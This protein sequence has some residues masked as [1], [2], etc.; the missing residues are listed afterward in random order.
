MATADIS[1][2]TLAAPFAGAPAAILEK[3]LQQ[4]AQRRNAQQ[5]WRGIA[6]SLTF[7]FAIASLMVLA[8]RL[9]FVDGEWWMPLIVI[10]LA[11]VVGIRN[12][13]LRH[14]T[15]FDAALDA[16]CAQGLQ[17]RL[18][19]AYAF[20]QPDAVR[21][22]YK[23]QPAT[24]KW[25]KLRARLLPN[26]QY[27]T[28]CRVA[29]TELVPALVHD[30][31]AHA[32]T[33]DAKA[34]YPLAHDRK[35]AGWLLGSVLLFS[36][37]CLM[38]NLEWL[39]SEAQRAFSAKL[40]AQGDKLV[41]LAKTVRDKDKLP[42]QNADADRLSKRLQN[43][44]KLMQ[45]GRMSKKEALV[46]M[47]QLREQLERA[48]QKDQQSQA[49]PDLEQLAQAL[50]DQQMESADGQQLK[51]D[52]EKGDHEKAAG[53][54]E[55][56]AQKLE[57]G[58]MSA[59]EA[60]KA[61]N[62]LEK[63]AQGLRR[64]GGAKNEEAAKQ[65][66]QA[67]QALR[68]QAGKS[69]GQN[70]QQ[71]QNGSNSGQSGSSQQKPQNQGAGGANGLRKLAAGLRKNGTQM[72]SGD[73]RAMLDKIAQ[74]ERDTGQNS[75]EQQ[76]GQQ[77]QNSNCPG[78]NC[79]GEGKGKTMKSSLAPSTT[80]PNGG[81][82]LG[83]RNGNQPHGSGGGVS[84]AKSTPGGDKRRW[85]DAW[86]DRLPKTHSKI[87]RITGKIGDDGEVDQL[88]TK[89]EAQG[90][91]VHTPYYQT[92]ESAKKSAEDAV[93]KDGALPPEYKQPVKDYFDSIK[94]STP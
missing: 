9:Y 51:Q 24:G 93:A 14:S 26:I 48:V 13:L 10:F 11:L 12:G 71:G 37:F 8:Y 2:N 85:E 31:A 76:D 72:G 59:Q 79:Q 67:A 87:D 60:Q 6:R 47:G 84:K 3:N 25:S 53:T 78:G 21:H 91:E 44:G 80:G 90:G 36:V 69:K 33:L 61:A 64:Q 19:S 20:I 38:P 5:L 83:P 34:V 23:T 46:A 57:Q 35:I 56:V 94:P 22:A 63:A 41:A 43:L 54:L 39:R 65:M 18:S 30:A 55:K 73:L 1:G 92:Y 81:P 29:P 7:G 66:E 52:L 50:R 82:G 27:R 58:K 68:Q 45:R 77:S 17:D 32:A 15:A 70:N 42:T 62:D 40:H 89:T 28:S 86:S 74:A 49:A 75:G 16:D 4:L 88:P